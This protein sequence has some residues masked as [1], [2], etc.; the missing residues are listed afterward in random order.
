MSKSTEVRFPKLLKN[1]SLGKIFPNSDLPE[2]RNVKFS[3]EFDLYK[4]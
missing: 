4:S 1:E 2:S 3:K